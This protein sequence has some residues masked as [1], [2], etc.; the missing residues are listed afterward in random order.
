MVVSAFSCEM[1]SGNSI[2]MG[3]SYSAMVASTFGSSRMQSPNACF[4]TW[5]K[6]PTQPRILRRIYLL[7]CPSIS[8]KAGIKD[9][10]LQ[11]PQSLGDCIYH[12][13]GTGTAVRLDIET[14]SESVGFFWS[15]LNSL[16]L[17]SSSFMS[18]YPPCCPILI[19]A[20]IANECIQDSI[21]FFTGSAH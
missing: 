7:S 21:S 19:K 15:R 1:V 2:T 18:M 17:S 12:Q 8:C 11:T 13:Y 6:L 4:L 10:T 20:S 3:M 9:E 14:A 5:L 16:P